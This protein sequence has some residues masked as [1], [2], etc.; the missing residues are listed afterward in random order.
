MRKNRVRAGFEPTNR[1]RQNG[2][3]AITTLVEVL[4]IGI[5]VWA[6]VVAIP[7]LLISANANSSAR[8]GDKNGP[9]MRLSVTSNGQ[10]LWIQRGVSEIVTVD[11]VTRQTHSVYRLNDR[12]IL[13]LCVS[14]EASTYLLS[15][16]DREVMIFRKKEL[17]VFE[18]SLDNSPQITALSSN[19]MMAT[20]IS[21]GTSVRCWD[22][23]SLDPVL[24]EFVLLESAGKI[25]LDSVG[26]RLVVSSNRGGLKVYDV[27]RGIPVQTL[28]ESDSIAIDLVFSEDG[29]WLVAVRN[30]SLALYDIRSGE[31]VWSI[32]A[33]ESD[34]F[35]SAAISSDGARIAASRLRT[36][37]HIL[38]RV[39]GMPCHH[40]SSDSVMYKM[41]F[42]PSNDTL[43]AGSADGS[44]RIW[45]LST[46]R[47]MERLK[48]L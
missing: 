14:Q 37:I 7:I 21:G 16:D 17:V 41:A 2:L 39:N 43:Y 30:Q 26:E 12:T 3:A 1:N 35:M 27:K 46:G 18:Q 45:S 47:E 13:G 25:A 9:I 19:G 8:E 42:S 22:L 36:G 24:S 33:S 6:V 40:F 38:D 44:I 29:R 10:Q 20:C 31:I 5:V 15:I 23:S 11:L 48:P 32:R 28:A 34:Y 4:L